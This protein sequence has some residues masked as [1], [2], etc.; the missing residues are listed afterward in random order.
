MSDD[1]PKGS[2]L[3]RPRVSSAAPHAPAP[4]RGDGLLR[5]R[6]AAPAQAAPAQAAPTPSPP[7]GISLEKPVGRPGP[8][9]SAEEPPA[10]AAS[11][12]DPCS[13]HDTLRQLRRDAPTL[14]ELLFPAQS[15]T[16]LL[17][18]L[19]GARRFEE[20]L[21]QVEADLREADRD[22]GDR[23]STR[24][25][26]VARQRLEAFLTKA[27]SG[28]DRYESAVAHLI[29]RQRSLLVEEI[30]RHPAPGTR[31][32]YGSD[33]LKIEQAAQ[34][35]GFAPAEARSVAEGEG[36]TLLTTE[37][38]QWVPC[39]SLPGSPS[40]LASVAR[41]LLEH[42][43]EAVAALRQR[44]VSSWLSAN[45]D[46]DTAAEIAAA[47]AAALQPGSESFARHAVAWRLGAREVRT[48]GWS[49]DSPEDL[50]RRWAAHA[51]DDR[52][53]VQ[54]A[55]SGVLGAWFASLDERVLEA[56]AH[57][58]AARPN[59]SL[60]L[61]QLRWSLGVPW[62][63]AGEAFADVRSLTDR[64]RAD[65]QVA[66]AAV[67]AASD[68]S[69]ASWLES[70]PAD[71]GD[72]VWQAALADPELKRQ[73]HSTGFWVG[74][75]RNALDRSLRLV[76]DG[77]LEPIASWR[78]LLSPA[79]SARYW[80]V[81]KPLRSSGELVAFLLNAPE[82]PVQLRAL[83]P[84]SPADPID[85]SLNALLWSLGATGMVLEWGVD[86]QPVQ[87]PEDLA[88]LYEDD[89]LRFEE[90]LAK[91]YPLTWLAPRLERHASSRMALDFIGRVMI[92]R[93]P[94][95]HAGAAVAALI[96]GGHASLPLD[97]RRPKDRRAVGLA[98]SGDPSGVDWGLFTAH[99]RSG[100]VA[101]WLLGQTPS[102]QSLAHDL[103][104]RWIHG[105]VPTVEEWLSW[106]APVGRP[107]ASH[108]F[109][110][111]TAKTP[112]PRQEAP[113][114]PLTSD[115][116]ASS[117]M[118]VLFLGALIL[119]AAA[120]AWRRAPIPTSLPRTISTA[121]PSRVPPTSPVP[122]P[123]PS[124]SPLLAPTTSPLPAPA[125]APA[126]E[127]QP[128]QSPLDRAEA[129]APAALSEPSTPMVVSAVVPQERC[130]IT[131]GPTE[132]ASYGNAGAGVTLARHGDQVGVGWIVAG[133]SDDRGA[134]DAA[135]AIL[136]MRGQVVRVLDAE[137][138][139]DTVYPDFSPRGIGRVTVVWDPHGEPQVVADE[140]V[141]EAN[142]EETIRCAGVSARWPVRP[143]TP[144]FDAR[145]GSATPPPSLTGPAGWSDELLQPYFCRTL[146]PEAPV[147][148]GQQLFAEAG[149]LPSRHAR[150]FV[151]PTAGAPL[152][153]LAELS[154]SR[155]LIRRVPEAANPRRL[156]KDHAGSEW[157]AARAEG[158]GYVVLWRD[159]TKIKGFW[160]DSSWQRVGPQWEVVT[161]DRHSAPAVQMQG[162]NGVLVFAT[163][164]Q[165]GDDASRSPF[166]VAAVRLR[167]GQAPAPFQWLGGPI[168]DPQLDHVAPSLT[169][170]PNAGWAVV[171][172]VRPRPGADNLAPG[173]R[174]D[175][176]N[177]LPVGPELQ[178]LMPAWRLLPNARDAEITA[179][180]SRLLV[181]AFSDSG[182]R[183]SRVFSIGAQCAPI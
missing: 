18:S 117:V 71:R 22:G 13:I 145:G 142:V 114:P 27:P 7:M 53:V 144:L 95:G 48:Q 40:T 14:I 16:E 141:A 59:D 113:S 123:S 171:F 39:G 161:N 119:G 30:H 62:S 56:R 164:Q 15:A 65:P 180:G 92:G 103:M 137:Q 45:G 134:D 64:V 136:S 175:A 149:G 44:A 9:A 94:G 182:S 6:E 19:P 87:A 165:P 81:L 154:M 101:C 155:T 159:R 74:V 66:A 178:P 61:Q 170:L 85:A 174:M 54:L 112:V 138:P 108:A 88:R 100:L 36:Y 29:S 83:P 124:P 167:F 47:E 69:L 183:R 115:R 52:V 42:E 43:G 98:P 150:V 26:R 50:G 139:D 147:V 68:G 133:R 78:P 130:S 146:A 8:A 126:R 5:R 106:L 111:L 181:V 102:A 176:V 132:I 24:D 97:P 31:V 118:P 166:R 121:V 158:F 110:D 73:G 21:R 46:H 58:V 76:R 25:V 156:L 116:T 91:G 3:L 135:A 4:P 96:H 72:V 129:Q 41:A 90:E 28:A 169:A 67:R 51:V 163:R 79:F 12:I 168:D 152:T 143:P 75:Y 35:L 140:M 177:L 49:F 162:M 33:V 179:F 82:D 77:V 120:L 93:A 86:D 104:R 20:R 109:G 153:P 34:R 173:D 60:L 57:A 10:P 172:T 38:R 131:D 151:A 1:P 107:R 80:D 105:G 55:R 32:L 84:F 17:R 157:R 122:S 63:L 99:F 2:G 70:L 23:F 148:V 127:S 37:A 11:L 160:V 125:S 128:T 89:P